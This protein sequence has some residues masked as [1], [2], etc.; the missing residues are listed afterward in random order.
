MSGLKAV[1]KLF[2]EKNNVEVLFSEYLF[3]YFNVNQYETAYCQCLSQCIPNDVFGGKQLMN[4]N[5][6]QG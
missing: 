6:C 2:Q 3:R 4:Y 1:L 5:I